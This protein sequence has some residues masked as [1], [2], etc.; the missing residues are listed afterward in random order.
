M[1]P[2]KWVRK[3]KTQVMVVVIFIAI[4]GFILGAWL[5]Q[6]A[7]RGTY[8]QVLGYY[9]NNKE[10]TNEDIINARN[11]LE[12][13]QKAGASSMLRNI[14]IAGFKALDLRAFL[15]GEL[16]FSEHS[17]SMQS[18]N[19]IKQSARNGEYNISVSQI[20]DIY[21]APPKLG[22]DICWLLL[23]REAQDAGI[24]I[25]PEV[26][27]SQLAKLIPPMFNVKYQDYINAMMEQN[28]I[29][30]GQIVG[31][32]VKLLEVL[33][34]SRAICSAEDVTSSQI[35]HLVSTDNENIDV[36]YV[37]VDSSVFSDAQPMPSEDKI[38]EQ[39]EKYKNNISGEV[40]EENPYGFGYKLPARVV[41]E[42][43]AVKLD[44][45]KATITP[46]TAEETE[47]YY[48]KNRDIFVE[49]IP[50]NPN[51]P[52]S[53]VTERTRSYA[54][55]AGA[56][57][58]Q[59]LDDKIKS[60]ADQILQDA[61]TI[62]EEGIK[63]FDIKSSKITI[64][65]LKEKVGDYKAA[66][67]SLNQ[68][69]KINIYSGKTGLLTAED[70]QQDKY[71]ST[72][73]IKGTG[74]NA[75]LL[76]D[77]AFAVDELKI[78]QL[79]PSEA[80]KPKLYENIGPLMQIPNRAQENTIGEIMAVAR[81][82]EAVPSVEP[83]NIDYKF[84][85][86]TLVLKQDSNSQ[87][88]KTYS[89]KKSVIDDLKRFE[90]METAKTK[91]EE[92]KELALKDGWDKAIEKFNDL[93]PKKDSNGTAE[94]NTFRLQVMPSLKQ[95]SLRKLM[96]LQDL[97]IGEASFETINSNNK[98]GA[99]FINQ[100]YSLVPKDKETPDNMPLVLEFK[101]DISY[102]CLKKLSVRHLNQDEYESIKAFEVYKNEVINTQ[103]LA[104]E[105]FNPVKITERMKYK[106]KE[107]EQE[108]KSTEEKTDSNTKPEDK[109]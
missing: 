33:T 7:T 107:P 18:F 1:N 64:K 61:K 23:T 41:F 68:K 72:L 9:D 50:S 103:S 55:M 60:K 79:G 11:E 8:K 13:M 101:P 47:E 59:L 36:E 31:A 93:Y 48:Q 97:T 91:A 24:T 88:N 29:S 76:I 46:P 86:Q 57:S 27:G 42:Y 44:E 52:N 5:Q 15:L 17:T 75:A 16:L 84:S 102:Y 10:I 95:I 90:A 94:P 71:L 4:V 2:L 40:S 99:M 14:G 25:P 65:E 78:S 108:K 45:I 73:Y 39:F 22:R 28:G 74:Y 53:P 51:E 69:Y 98:K 80:L 37:K 85:T 12:I 34:Y 105:F 106:E 20:E 81:I 49:K 82:V 30:E 26:A 77:A 92:L 67:A 96:T 3:N 21:N 63:D 62:T 35:T 54:E 104:V 109:K 66:A 70:M 87:E 19:I 38:T 89:V 58:K 56:I 83:E 43:I 6:Q 100:L 32:F